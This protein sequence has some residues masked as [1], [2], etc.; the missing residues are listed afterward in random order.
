MLRTFRREALEQ[1]S[2]RPRYSISAGRLP[3]VELVVELV[4]GRGSLAS[5]Q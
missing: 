1:D 3:V 2:L 4:V 5:R